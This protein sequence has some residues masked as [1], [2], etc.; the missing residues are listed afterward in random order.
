MPTK[1]D[2]EKLPFKLNQRKKLT[3][4]QKEIIKERYKR[5][6]LSQRELASEYGVSRRLIVFCIYPERYELAKS[7]RRKAWEEGKYR[8]YYNKEKHRKAMKSI[9]DRKK[10]Y[11][12]D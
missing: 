3:P 7:R 11:Y 2:K 12:K 8:Y 4:Q 9:R 10:S 1:L 6:G 5:G